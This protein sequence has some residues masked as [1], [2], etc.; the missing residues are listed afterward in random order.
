MSTSQWSPQSSPGIQD[1]GTWAQEVTSGYVG[2][3][4]KQR[5]RS[6]LWKQTRDFLSLPGAKRGTFSRTKNSSMEVRGK[7]SLYEL[8][9]LKTWASGHKS[10]W[11]LSLLMSAKKKGKP[12]QLKCSLSLTIYH[13]SLHAAYLLNSWLCVDTIIFLVRHFPINLWL[14]HWPETSE[15]GNKCNPV[16]VVCLVTE[17]G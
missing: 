5:E 1:W 17:Q 7:G 9:W 13:W 6:L 8:Q 16:R 10:K 14:H 2:S 15:K 3:Q 12:P 11:I 4:T